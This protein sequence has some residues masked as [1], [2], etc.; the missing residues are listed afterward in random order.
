MCEQL[1]KERYFKYK[2]Y[3]NSDSF[4]CIKEEKYPIIEL[5]GIKWKKVNIKIW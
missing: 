3:K 4:L 2:F 1:K 5:G